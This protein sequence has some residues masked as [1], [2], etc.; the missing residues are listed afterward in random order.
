NTSAWLDGVQFLDEGKVVHPEL[1]P[2][3]EK[4]GKA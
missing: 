3:A 2:L 1:L 4:L